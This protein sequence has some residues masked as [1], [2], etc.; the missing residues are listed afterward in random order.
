M[1]AWGT[2]AGRCLPGSVLW[3]Q[4]GK[5]LTYVRPFAARHLGKPQSGS[6]TKW[7]TEH[8]SSPPPLVRT[9]RLWKVVVAVWPG[10]C[11]ECIKPVHQPHGWC[12]RA[13]RA[14]D[15]NGGRGT[16]LFTLGHRSH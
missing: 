16:G 5:E 3:E 12:N 1:P 7:L 8:I 10:T 14:G 11:K 15:L 6:A 2:E 4:T 9:I 13:G